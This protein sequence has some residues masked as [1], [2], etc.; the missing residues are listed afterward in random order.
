M[1]TYLIIAS[2]SAF[3]F[4]SIVDVISLYAR[5]ACAA[6]SKNAIGGHAALVIS[7]LN[8]GF[9]TIYLLSIALLVDNGVEWSILVQSFGYSL[10]ISGIAIY[11]IAIQRQKIYHLIWWLYKIKKIEN[12]L[13]FAHQDIKLDKRSA[14]SYFVYKVNAI[15]LTVPFILASINQD[16]RASLTQVGAIINMLS[17]IVNTVYLERKIAYGFE[18][19]DKKTSE[20]IIFRIIQGRIFALLSAGVLY[21]IISKI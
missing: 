4:S 11:L 14:V 10:I 6:V 1:N 20:I 9:I 19:E 17:T 7:L 2:A 18:S 8:R 3:A 15:G 13:K 21:I 5:S 12:Y 16:Y